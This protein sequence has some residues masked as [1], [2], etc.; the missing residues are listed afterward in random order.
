MA[1]LSQ[2]SLEMEVFGNAGMW[3]AP[4]GPYSEKHEKAAGY[5]AAVKA[6]AL[7]DAYC[8]RFASKTALGTVA[9][10]VYIKAPTSVTDPSKPT[11]KK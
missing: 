9:P 7:H 1:R 6:A 4:R 3:S 10:L 5:A 2:D 11:S 8:S